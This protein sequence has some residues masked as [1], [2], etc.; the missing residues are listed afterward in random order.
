MKALSAQEKRDI[1]TQVEAYVKKVLA[2]EKAAH[3]FYHINRVRKVALKIAKEEGANMFLVELMTL[4]HETGDSKIVGK[5]NEKKSLLKLHQFLSSL[6]ISDLNI[7]EI[8]Y[9]INNQSYSKT[10]ISGKKLDSLA[11]QCAQDADRLEAIGAIGIA[12]CF[13]YHGKTNRLIYDP[14]I[15]PNLNQTKEQYDKYENTAINHFYEKMLKLKDLMNTKTGK[16]LAEHRH[17]FMEKFLEEFFA[18]WNGE[19]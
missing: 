6:N 4:L 12:R 18:E 17:K 10:G 11:G 15:P 8:L 13:A 3:D 2:R 14:V 19:K 5:G 7:E 1:I 9:V 16:K